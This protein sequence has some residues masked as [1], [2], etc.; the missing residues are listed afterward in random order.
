V[1]AEPGRG[2]PGLFGEEGRGLEPHPGG[3]IEVI[4]GPMFSG[5]TEELIRRLRRALIARRRVVILKPGLDPSLGR[6]I[7]AA[8]QA[9]CLL[10][11]QDPNLV[12]AIIAIESSFNPNAVSP[13]GAVGLMQ[14][15]PFWKKTLGLK[16]ELSDPEVS[17]RAGVQVL[18]HYGQ[19][20]RDEALTL[21]AYNR[22]PG[23]VDFALASGNSLAKGY[24]EKVL[25]TWQRLKDIDVAG[26]P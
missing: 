9:N 1:I 15:M 14:V 2:S 25:S 23:P 18:A 24:A 10:Y 6:R 12:L 7:A 4:C 26:R 3:V 16:E 5:K 21:A 11:G 19:M 8:V 20:Y 17:I 22:G 13:V